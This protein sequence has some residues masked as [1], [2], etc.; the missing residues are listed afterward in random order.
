MQPSQ[1]NGM[2]VL[3]DVLAATH[4]G[5][6]LFCRSELAAPWGMLFE[7]A[8]RAGLH[9]VA[10]GSCWLRT[11][12][13][14]EPLHL[15]QGDVV[16]LPHGAGHGLISA[17][18]VQP[19]P[20]P[21]LLGRCQVSQGANGMSLS[22]EG[23]GPTTVLL[24]G[25]YS[26]EHE[27]VHPLLSLLPPLIHLRADAGLLSGP[28]ESVLRLLVAEYTQPGP[29]SVTVTSRLVDVLFIHII[30]GWLEQQPEGSAGWLGA[31]R[32]AQVGR[33]L[34]LM[35]GEPQRDWTVESLAVEVACSRATFSRRFRELVGEPPLVYL[36]RLRMD[37]AA[38]MLRDSNQ[39]L[40]GIAER[41]GYAS[42]F[43]FNRT[44]HRVRGVPPGRYREQARDAAEVAA[45]DGGMMSM[46][47]PPQ[48]TAALLA[49]SDVRP[50]ASRG[51]E[52]P[53]PMRAPGK[54]STPAVRR[55]GAVSARRPATASV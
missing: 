46:P 45:S 1:R 37:V 24:C 15:A 12:G 49:R 44:F 6:T 14:S 50:L 28:L 23:K 13:R 20:F 22:L 32:D 19:L 27:G 2:D 34:A 17:P 48:R 7:P 26:F 41:V 30:R 47:T 33:A 52:A 29:G 8:S 11:R 4:I 51:S 43:A 18:N 36:T 42:E 54:P 35:H 3:A 25:V 10:R 40:A 16:L 53:G 55:S 5:G 39:P 38:R 9:I 31:V 21:K